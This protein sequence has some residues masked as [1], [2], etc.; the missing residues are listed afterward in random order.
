VGLIA[1]KRHQAINLGVAQ[2]QDAAEVTAQRNPALGAALGRDRD[3]ERI[4]DNYRIGHR[5][6]KSSGASNNKVFVIIIA[7]S[8]A[9]SYAMG[10]MNDSPLTGSTFRPIAGLAGY[11]GLGSTNTAK[12]SAMT[13]L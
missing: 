6:L 11:L 3:A 8:I 7:K 9:V 1:D 12:V 4:R 13:S 2:S 5:F 10:M